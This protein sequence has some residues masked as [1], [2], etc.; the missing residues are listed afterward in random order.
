MGPDTDGIQDLPTRVIM[1]QLAMVGDKVGTRSIFGHS[2]RFNLRG[3][4]S[5]KWELV[6]V[7]ETGT[8]MVQ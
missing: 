3:V 2:M 5:S 4:L 8:G 7:W 1:I 6:A